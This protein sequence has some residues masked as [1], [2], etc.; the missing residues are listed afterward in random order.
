MIEPWADPAVVV[1]ARIERIAAAPAVVTVAIDGRSGAGKSTLA[2]RLTDCIDA[3]VIEGDDFYAGGT[4]E[5]W[6]SMTPAERVTHCIDWRRQRPVIEA[7]AAGH[8]ATWQ[9]YDWEAFDGR[10]STVAMTAAPAPVVI[11][12]GAYSARPELADIFDLRVLLDTPIA[13][14][15]EQLRRREG[16]D[17]R[18]QWEAVWSTAEDHY[19]GEVMTPGDFDLV[20]GGE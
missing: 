5:E 13:R 9:P 8:R 17:F 2:R 16:A 14:R 19:F 6:Q 3:I 15:R 7:L 18:E 1:R 20:V 11:L 10:L 4:N 12:E